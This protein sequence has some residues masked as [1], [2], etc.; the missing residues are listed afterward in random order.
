MSRYK[1]IVKMTIAVILLFSAI[2]LKAAADGPGV[3]AH[4]AVLMEQES[5]RVLFGRDEH[6]PMR[7][8]SITKI[9]TA[10][11]AVE[12]GKLEQRVKISNSAAG[13]EGSS[14][15]LKPG[16][17]VLLKDLVYGLMLRSGNDSAVAIAEYVGGS[18]D[19]FVYMMNEKAREIGMKDTLFQN[20]HGLDDHED[21]YSSAFDM[22][23][24]TRYAMENDR[25]KEISA[26]EV[27]RSPQEGE[28]WDR[29]WRNKNKMLK[30]YKYSTGGKT[31]Y[32]KRAKRTLVST[33]E[34]N[35]MELIA[36]TLNDPNDWD[37]H[38]RMFEWGF[39]QF[40]LVPIVK[41]GPVSGVQK[42]YKNKVE[43]NRTFYYPL[44]ES[45][46]Q[47]ISSTINVY[48]YPK[49]GKWKNG[50]APKPI[51]RLF[52]ELAGVEI[53]NL[54]LYYEGEALIKEDI[55]VWK[56]LRQMFSQF[57]FVKA[58]DSTDG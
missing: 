5:G 23:L 35:G 45:E 10:I 49:D 6:S 31:G 42:A 25:F 52:I 4:G 8:A 32:T 47:D 1:T 51:G 22:A 12:S 11:I 58:E 17:T 36:V 33:A 9:M 7:I 41:K 37:D 14:L 21:H 27:Y 39:H 20:P 13:T 24:L 50:E 54:P 38:E 3:S 15:Y 29:V 30:Y 2:P 48:R 19:G 57:F 34:K 28:K 43:A 53:G 26:T 18:L 40:D 44:K 16:E 46:K 55:G 56:S